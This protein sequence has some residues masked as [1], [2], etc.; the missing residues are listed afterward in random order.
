MKN[1][2]SRYLNRS[3]TAGYAGYSVE[4]SIKAMGRDLPKLAKNHFMDEM[5]KYSSVIDECYDSFQGGKKETLLIAG[6]LRACTAIIFASQYTDKEDRLARFSI[7]LSKMFIVLIAELRD[8]N[9][10]PQVINEEVIKHLELAAQAA[11]VAEAM[12]Y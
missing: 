11:Y 7:K 3:K 1:P 5:L 8:S 6:A 2:L 9:E 12:D 10:H 4:Q